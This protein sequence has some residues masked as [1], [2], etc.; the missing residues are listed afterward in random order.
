MRLNMNKKAPILV[1]GAMDIEIEV[2]KNSIE[3]I[4][5][6]IVDGY[7]FY[8]GKLE[9]YPIIISKTEIGIMNCGIATLLGIKNF[10]PCIIINQGTLGGFGNIHR[11]D[12]VIGQD[13]FNLNSYKTP[14][15]KKGEGSNP[16]NWDLQ[17][18]REGI[19]EFEKIE[20]D[21]NI[22]QFIKTHEKE[23]WK[24]RLIYG[25]IGS[26]DCW[27]QEIDYI[28]YLNEKYGALGE[29]METIGAY[30]IAHRYKIPIV[31][32]RVVSDNEILQE[33]YDRTIAV[34]AQE[35]AISLCKQWVLKEGNK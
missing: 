19:D 33:E 17:T 34:K 15:L 21:T 3:D 32:I 4:E 31:G 2:L 11:G 20:A 14:Y 29:D 24:D 5:E 7:K 30:K 6:I 1:Q 23:I 35:C 22:I 13:C 26:G 12:I 9:G 18:F 8:K 16:F 28:T 10:L 27:N 25:T